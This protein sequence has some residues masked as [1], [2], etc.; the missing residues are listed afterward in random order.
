[1][2]L[3]GD[4][5][6]DVTRDQ[7]ISDALAM[8]GAIGP[9]KD[10]TGREREFAARA[11][12]R[13]CKSIDAEGKFLWRRAR[14]SLSLTAGTATYSLGA[15]VMWIDD[16]GN[17]RTSAAA[18]SRVPRIQAIS[19][20]D[21][22]ALTDRSQQGTPIKFITEHT[23]TAPLSITFWPVPDTTGAVFEYVACLRASDYDTGANTGDYPSRWGQALV[24]GLAAA[25]APAYSQMALGRDLL[26]QYEDEKRKQ[27]AA[28]EERA[29]TIF[30]PFG[31]WSM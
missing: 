4:T 9:G 6:F 31:D 24:L 29:R 12:N 19:L 16:E 25:M 2:S 8:V 30:V 5:T 22:I 20:Q 23:L 18:T 27:M 13:I 17:Y 11:L 21:F 26:R 10:A 14:R 3:S 28:G 15:D 7:I 1:M